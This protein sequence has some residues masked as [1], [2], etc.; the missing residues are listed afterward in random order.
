MR[1]S[2]RE[3]AEPRLEPRPLSPGI[4][5]SSVSGGSFSAWEGGCP[6]LSLVLSQDS[7]TPF[8]Q[9]SGFPCVLILS[10]FQHS[11]SLLTSLGLSFF[12]FKMGSSLLSLLSGLLWLHP[13]SR[14]LGQPS[15]LPETSRELVA[16]LASASP[17]GPN[18]FLN[19]PLNWL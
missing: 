17:S 12:T 14:G 8:F 4:I 19:Y 16:E 15:A 5:L 10:S 11:S 3:V 6:A 9:A 13:V 18:F 1:R 7:I 2:S